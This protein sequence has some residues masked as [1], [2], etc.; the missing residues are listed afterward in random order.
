MP[1]VRSAPYGRRPRLL[2][3]LQARPSPKTCSRG[4]YSI[5][6]PGPA[7]RRAAPLGPMTRRAL[8]TRRPRGGDAGGARPPEV[9]AFPRR[10]APAGAED[11]L[12][13]SPRPPHDLSTPGWRPERL[14]SAPADR[15]VR[16][17]ATARG[18]G[19]RA[20]AG[21][22]CRPSPGLPSQVRPQD[23]PHALPPGRRPPDRGRARRSPAGPR[24][25]DLRRFDRPGH[26]R[27]RDR[28]C[29]HRSPA[30]PLRSRRPRP[31][32]PRS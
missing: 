17:T 23:A 8:A 2:A 9:D 7:A 26:R 31:R 24:G 15:R 14:G 10:S 20:D 25:R 28:S 19:M 30:L 32:R 27:R 13:A 6:P 1:L 11:V 12:A 4:A 16:Q 29:D 21:K 3:A 18:A 22:P 5:H